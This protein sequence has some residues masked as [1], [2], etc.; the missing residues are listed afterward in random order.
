MK[1]H[2]AVHWQPIKSKQSKSYVVDSIDLNRIER[3]LP[4]KLPRSHSVVINLENVYKSFKTSLQKTFV[5]KDINL[6]FYAGEFVIVYGPS[7]C[8]KSTLLHTILGLEEPSKG[9]VLLRDTNL[10]HLSSD[11]RSNFRRQKIGIVFQQSNWVKSLS[12]LDNVAYPLWLDGYQ[13]QEAREKALETLQSVGMDKYAKQRPSELSG[14]QQQKV[15]LARAL[16]T[17]PW[18][19]ICD[20]PTGNLD[21]LSSSEIMTLLAKLN[22]VKRRLII[23]VTHDMS[24]L[25]LATRR[26]A[27]KDGVVMHD[28]RDFFRRKLSL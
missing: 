23:M 27:M 17:D 2:Q 19:I 9:K 20:E 21:S 4:S 3:S 16:V 28:E 12:V 7:G 8:G 5:L 18:V 11:K 10:Y 13:E 22:R 6:S 15:A 25:P 1:N 24:F 14:G 26:V